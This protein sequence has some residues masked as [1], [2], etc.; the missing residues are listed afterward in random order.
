MKVIACL[1]AALIGVCFECPAAP[2]RIKPGADTCFLLQADGDRVVD[3]A[4]KYRPRDILA[5]GF[6]VVDDPEMGEVLQF[7]QGSGLIQVPD[8][9]KISYRD[10]FTFEALVYLE[11]PIVKGRCLLVERRSKKSWGRWP[12]AFG[13]R[14]NGKLSLE[15][16][17][18]EGE[19]ID[20][21]DVPGLKRDYMKPDLMYPSRCNGM[22]GFRNIPVGRW[23]RVSF[24]YDRPRRLV[25]MCVD[26][27]ID[28]QGFNP[29]A[30]I[31]DVVV[32]EDDSPIELF[33]DAHNL[34]VAQVHF[35]S[36]PVQDPLLPPVAIYVHELAYWAKQYVHV[37]PTTDRLPLPVEVVVENIDSQYP[38][39]PLRYELKDLEPHNYPIPEHRSKCVPTVLVVRI[40]K[41]GRE[42]YSHETVVMNLEV[43]SEACS[44]AFRNL[45][46]VGS[47]ARP[48]WWIEKDNTITYKGKPIFPIQICGVKTNDLETVA[49]LGFNCVSLSVDIAPIEATQRIPFLRS[50]Y[51]KAAA[52]GLTVTTDVTAANGGPG[53]GFVRLIDEPWGASFEAYRSQYMNERNAHRR[54]TLQPMYIAQ[55]NWQRYRDTGACCDILGVDPYWNGRQPMRSIYDS[56]QAAIRATD[57]GKPISVSVGNYGPANKHHGFEQLRAMTIFGIIGG[58]RALNYYTWDDGKWNG[59]STDTA[60]MP[61]SVASYRK[62]LGELKSVYP[63]LLVPNAK[64]GPTFDSKTR[65]FFACAKRPE[66]GALTLFVASD[67]YRP[68]RRTMVWKTAAG[69]TA[70]IVSAPPEGGEATKT[71]VF[72][73]Q[74]RA[75]LALPP[76]SAAIF[77]F[78]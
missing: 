23:T 67:L 78:D 42:L 9:G 5:K 28:R 70:R 24:T 56:V 45:G 52:L 51:E 64:D 3:A 4:G 20:Y 11:E 44:S 13:I 17:A 48:D 59:E 1:S 50:W 57:G 2:E 39:E 6:R 15:H 63:A 18:L 61:E 41:D 30:A 12:F 75:E 73:G 32:D 38:T 49:S 47:K 14:E 40:V 60:G 27:G 19:P 34:R 26:G 37:V 74:G 55:N 72:D 68:A 35:T 77:A 10:G 65:G 29:F 58:A 25:R 7:G 46:W 33:R 31:A 66:K 71:L 21:A 76:L 62:L 53:Q 22:N 36:K 16:I 54:L 43:L 69:K 8:G